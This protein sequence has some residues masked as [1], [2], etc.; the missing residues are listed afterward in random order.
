MRRPHRGWY[1]LRPRST[2]A[3]S[4]K[5][6]HP[7][8]AFARVGFDR[9]ESRGSVALSHPPCTHVSYSFMVNPP[10]PYAPH[11]LY[12]PLGRA[13][14]ARVAQ[15][16]ARAVRGRRERRRGVPRC[17]AERALRRARP[18]ARPHGGR[19]YAARR[20]APRALSSERLACDRYSLVAV[21]KTPPT[22]DPSH[23][24]FD[25]GAG[26][27]DPFATLSIGPQRR[28]STV[29]RKTLAPEWCE[30]FTFHL[31]VR[32]HYND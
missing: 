16:G 21:V 14:P 8:P 1:E 24:L 25:A 32:W 10:S 5:D 27:S 20:F 22:P 19:P 31:E 6:K 4:A 2:K 26:S 28:K 13:S 7:P 18:R 30:P 15:P 17:A 3:A 29:K 9:E 11:H 12:L 23:C